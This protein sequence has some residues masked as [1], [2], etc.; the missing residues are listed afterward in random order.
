MR[1]QNRV[2]SEDDI[3]LE[4]RVAENA[5]ENIRGRGAVIWRERTS[6]RYR[7][8]CLRPMVAKTGLLRSRECH[9]GVDVG[10]DGWSD[11]GEGTRKVDEHP[12]SGTE[13]S[14]ERAGRWI[15]LLGGPDEREILGLDEKDRCDSG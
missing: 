7:R 8:M 15:C 14:A 10:R 4:E 9:K 13:R 3:S 2:A 1:S 5:R 12:R 6:D 11:R